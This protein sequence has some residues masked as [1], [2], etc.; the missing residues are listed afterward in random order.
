MAPRIPAHI[1]DQIDTMLRS[2]AR[3][4]D[5]VAATN[6]AYRT[7]WK[8]R[9]NLQD[10]G[11]VTRPRMK[12]SGRPK[13]I[14]ETAEQVKLLQ[15]V[16]D[17]PTAELDDM[18]QFIRREEGLVV[19]LATMSRYLKANGWPQRATKSLAAKTSAQPKAKPAQGPS[20]AQTGEPQNLSPPSGTSSTSFTKTAIACWKLMTSDLSPVSLF[21]AEGTEHIRQ[22]DGSP[23]GEHYDPLREQ[24]ARDTS[25]PGSVFE[26]SRSHSGT[27]TGRYKRSDKTAH[28]PGMKAPLWVEGDEKGI[29]AFDQ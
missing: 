18:V 4:N 10:F 16:K 23:N 22:E 20:H 17:H 21:T 3:I 24:H 27:K 11:R 5:I 14:V 1:R 13:L 8:L 28:N 15:F 6:T 26:P 25:N 9:K 29:V 7:I 12:R 2:G 19:S